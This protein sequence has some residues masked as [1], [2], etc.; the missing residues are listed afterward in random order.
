MNSFR[1]LSLLSLAA[2]IAF[3]SACTCDRTKK[4]DTTAAID[5]S[6]LNDVN[7]QK[8]VFYSLPSPLETAMLLKS[9]NA[10]Y[11]EKLLNPI[12]NAQRY[13]TNSSMALNMGI[14]ITDLS[15]ASLF[16]QTQTTINY[17]N[18]AKKLA[19]NLGIADAISND[20]LKKIQ[21]NI[22]NKDVINDVISEAFMSSSSYLKE[23]NREPIATIILAGGWIEGLYIA[24]SLVDERNFHRNE[25]LIERVLDQKMTLEILFKMFD[26]YKN[27]QELVNLRPIFDSLI[28]YFDKIVVSSSSNVKVEFDEKTQTTTL[29]S[30]SK[31]T[32]SKADFIALATRIQVIRS[33]FIR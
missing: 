12:S 7:S 13:T 5:S 3:N 26:Q 17:M 24:T 21:N 14:Y 11:N 22:N 20:M 10:T 2:F 1:T 15:F 33:E 18:T 27:N 28:P 31:F 30:G 29:D 19:E 23:N 8:K 25:K 4:K 16:D 9:A 32:I 6:L